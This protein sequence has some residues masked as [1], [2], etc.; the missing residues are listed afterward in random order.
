MVNAVNEKADS[1]NIRIKLK[2]K[3]DLESLAE[4][5]KETHDEIV[6]RL[7]KLYKGGTIGDQETTANVKR[8]GK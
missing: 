8:R 4:R 3:A 1:T 6:A 5:F 7:I 2:T